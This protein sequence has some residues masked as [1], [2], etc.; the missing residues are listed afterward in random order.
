MSP[1]SRRHFL[2]AAS[3]AALA[4]AMAIKKEDK[5]SLPVISKRVEKV[6]MA[7]GR[8][9]NDLETVA[10]GLW[11]LDQADPNKAHK[12]RWEDGKV[13]AEVQT[14]AMHGSGIA[15]YD[16]A[17]WIAST[18]SGPCP[19]C[20]KTMKV[21]AKTGKTLAMWDSPGAVEARMGRP[22]RAPGQAPTPG[23]SHGIKFVDGFYWEASPPAIT[24]FK[25]EPNTGKIV[26]KIP[27]PGK[28]PH[29][30]AWENGYLW[31]IESNDRAVY[32]MDP[33][34][35][36]LLAKIQLTKDDPT[37]HGLTIRNGVLWYC[38][39]ESRW[40]CRLV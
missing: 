13:L 35:G 19:T 6:F 11:I 40:V 4:N 5:S 9:P 26:H 15:F 25:V 38:D 2:A 21:D 33:E 16:N 7:P 37:P 22:G 32:K 18:A 14:E 20:L 31:C 28:R 27:A 24:I 23:G 12:V 36:D 8:H 30:L 17:L 1:V 10:D 29:G 3:T 39:A 34:T